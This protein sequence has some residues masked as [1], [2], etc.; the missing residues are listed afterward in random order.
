MS[1][2][3]VDAPELIRSSRPPEITSTR[4]GWMGTR[5]CVSAKSRA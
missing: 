2:Q 3:V 1:C 5:G 4:S